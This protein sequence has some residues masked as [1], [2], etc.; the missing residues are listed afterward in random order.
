MGST[1]QS[2][3]PPGTRL[4][5]VGQSWTERPPTLRAV[6]SD[7]GRVCP[8]PVALVR[9][10]SFVFTGNWRPFGDSGGR[11]EES[12]SFKVVSLRERC[13]E[14][15]RLRSCSGC[16]RWRLGLRRSLNTVF[17]SLHAPFCLNADVFM[18]TLTPSG[19]P[20]FVSRPLH[21]RVVLGVGVPGSLCT[22]RR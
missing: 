14:R 18:P 20:V 21:G 13:N 2:M 7:S 3:S 5:L 6:L 1:V 16:V 19:G 10:L 4:P 11:T 15:G 17:V 8:T 22:P 9:A 12:L